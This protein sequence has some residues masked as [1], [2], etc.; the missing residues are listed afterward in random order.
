M[1][2][3]T[4]TVSTT[5]PSSIRPLPFRSQ[6]SCQFSISWLFWPFS[7]Q[8]GVRGNSSFFAVFI[9]AAILKMC[10]K[11]FINFRL[12]AY[13]EKSVKLPFSE[14]RT[15]TASVFALIVLTAYHSVRFEPICHGFFT[16]LT[17]FWLFYSHN[18]VTRIVFKRP[19]FRNEI[20]SLFWIFGVLTSNSPL[21]VFNSSFVSFC[22]KTFD[23]KIFISLDFE[24]VENNLLFAVTFA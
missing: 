20:F 15:L 21:I 1:S 8:E 13:N 7:P 23:V 9:S 6:W 4:F 18:W 22:T 2:A 14:F 24:S 12:K 11:K 16:G 10:W 19:N 17:T 5:S 3:Q